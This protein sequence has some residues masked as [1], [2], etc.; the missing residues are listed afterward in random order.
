MQYIHKTEAA[1][2]MTLKAYSDLVCVLV[3]DRRGESVSCMFYFFEI[4][5]VKAP[6]ILGVYRSL[7]LDTNATSNR[8]TLG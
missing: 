3:C 7:M 8:H 1:G 4:E 2:T 5:E 6:V